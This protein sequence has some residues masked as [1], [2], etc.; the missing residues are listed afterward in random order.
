MIMATIDKCTT[1]LYLY[2]HSNYIKMA[3]YDAY[4]SYYAVDGK[5][6]M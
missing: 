4:D 3:Q 5:I 1:T 6:I 2:D